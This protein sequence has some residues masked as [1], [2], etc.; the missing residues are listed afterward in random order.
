MASYIEDLIK[1]WADDDMTAVNLR[2]N[3]LEGRLFKSYEPNK[4]LNGEFWERCEAWLKNV[5]T[6]EEKKTLYRLLTQILYVGP[7]EFEELFRCAYDGP[8]SRWLIDREQIDICATN[9]Q[10][11]L[12]K[13]AEETWFCPVTDSF[14][15]NSFFHI[16]NLAANANLRPDW[17]SLHAL[18]DVCKLRCYCKSKGIKRL[19]LLEDFVGGGSQSL[20][21]VRFAAADVDD[22]EVLFAPM[23]ICPDGAESARALEVALNA[24]RA[25]SLRF[26]PVLE[27]PRS[28]FFTPTE[29][30]FSASE[31]DALRQVINASYAAV[32]GGSTTG[33]PYHMYGFP[34]ARPTGGLVVMFTNTPDNTLPLVHWR[35]ANGAWQP[36]FP[37]HSRV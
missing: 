7:A 31:T 27:L 18:G 15:I 36:V 29:S 10:Q 13:A 4:F 26:D 20:D 8:I 6:D 2:V 12:T 22:L 5:N 11:R 37:R 21:A 30:S 14:R 32:S 35:P 19:V 34:Q 17:C 23:I 28:A 1:A 3:H 25:G 16:N 24:R 9:A 33:K